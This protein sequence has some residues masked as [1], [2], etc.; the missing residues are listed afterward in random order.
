MS[1]ELQMI[2][3]QKGL[4]QEDNGTMRTTQATRCGR[5]VKT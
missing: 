3:W 5:V 4:E 1:A 2:F